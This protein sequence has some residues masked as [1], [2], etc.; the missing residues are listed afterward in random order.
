MIGLATVPGRRR[1]RFGILALVDH[2]I[3]LLLCLLHP[4]ADPLLVENPEL[5]AE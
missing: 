3:E 1:V 4:E 2:L 5:A